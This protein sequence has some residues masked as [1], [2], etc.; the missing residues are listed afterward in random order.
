MES[1]KETCIDGY[2]PLGSDYTY[3]TIWVELKSK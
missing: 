3:N 1:N 2:G